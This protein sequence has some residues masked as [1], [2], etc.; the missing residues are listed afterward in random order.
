MPL[1]S[2]LKGRPKNKDITWGK[3]QQQAFETLKTALVT[4]PIL[5]YPEPHGTYI[6]DTDASN[7]AYGAV[8]SQLQ[9]AADG[10]L[11]ERVIA[12]HSK[13]LNSAEQRYC[14]R[15]RELLA[16]VRAVKYFEVYLR[17]PKFIIRTDHASLQYIKTLTTMPDQMYRW[18]LTLEQY[19][20]VIQVRPGK[21]HTNADTLSRVPCA[22]KIC[23]CEQVE[24]YELRAKTKVGTVTADGE[25]ALNSRYKAVVNVINFQPKWSNEDMRRRQQTDLDIGRC[26]KPSWPT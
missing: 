12:Y 9:P 16:I 18:I 24:E 11:V 7:F 22:G 20:Y 6:L 19:D 13:I 25:D 15:R 8:L 21:D 5:A 26:T 2:L 1:Y 4:A 10:Q 17:G 23:I 3:P 14:A